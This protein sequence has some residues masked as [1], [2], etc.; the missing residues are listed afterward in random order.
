MPGRTSESVRVSQSED[1]HYRC[2]FCSRACATYPM[3]RRHELAC[4]HR[5]DLRKYAEY[6]LDRHVAWLER[7]DQR[8]WR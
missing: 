4:P 7:Q 6:L 8:N 5:R 1:R 2:V 3:L